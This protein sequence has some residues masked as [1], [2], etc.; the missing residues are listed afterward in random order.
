MALLTWTHTALT[1]QIVFG[2]DAVDR[3]GAQMK[4]IGARR[5]LLV[6]S[7]DRAASDEG[8]RVARAL[9]RSLASTFAQVEPYGPTHVVR[10]AI[11]QARRD[12]VDAVVSLGGGSAI[13]LAKA[14]AY[15]HEQE[16]G[17]PGVTHLDRPLLPHVAVPLTYSGAEST[18]FF[19]IT[20]ERTRITSGAGGP[21]S[22]PV[23]VVYDPR[24][25][26][27]VPTAVSVQTAMTALAHCVEAVCAT[28]RSPEAEAIALEG[29]R[30]VAA[31][32]PVVAADPTDL[33]ARAGLLSAAALAGRALQNAATGVQHGLAQLLGARSGIPHGL[34]SAVLLAPCMRFNA[35]VVPEQL[36][37]IGAALGVAAD[38]D[39]AVAAV[40]AMRRRVGIVP[41][42]GIAVADLDAVARASV[43]HPGVTGNP[44]PVG[45][46]DARGLLAEALA[47]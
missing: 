40:D 5:V 25:T 17:A 32:L 18:P 16:Q 6:T 39:A 12:G 15:F 2:L 9:G 19:G 30:L 22:A 31:H 14:V 11:A 24:L 33:E 34:A 26:L 44:R 7:A 29:A 37:R 38:A 3:L 20:D 43:G 28:V 27:S 45:I 36:A 42:D 8:A 47:D 1:Q 4:A 13:D 10:A 23:G 35:L 41:P 21:T 46:D